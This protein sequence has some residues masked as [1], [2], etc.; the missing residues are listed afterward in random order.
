MATYVRARIDEETK[1]AASAALE[2]M[3]LTVS[4]AIRMLLRR[5]ADEGVMPF[6]V[7]VP[8]AETLEAMRELEA[9]GGERYTLDEFTALLKELASENT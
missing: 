1:G 7:R 2:K 6:D 5:V 4:D 9:G 3:G 8:N